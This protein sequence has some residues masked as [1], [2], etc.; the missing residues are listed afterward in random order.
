ML[1]QGVFIKRIHDDARL[2]RSPALAGTLSRSRDRYEK[3]FRLIGKYRGTIFVPTTEID[4]LWHTQQCYPKLYY[5]F[6]NLVTGIAGDAGVDWQKR[7]AWRYVDHNDRLDKG[8]L[9][10][11]FEDTER[12]WKVEYVSAELVEPAPKGWKRV[13][14]DREK[15]PPVSLPAEEDENEGAAG[16]EGNKEKGVEAEQKGQGG[17]SEINTPAKQ[18]QNLI[19]NSEN[20][21][22]DRKYNICVNWV[23]ELRKNMEEEKTMREGKRAVEERFTRKEEW[24]MRATVHYYR[25]VEQARVEG[26]MLPVWRDGK[27]WMRSS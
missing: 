7:G 11:G 19:D 22:G 3:F 17:V 8:I 1:R 16:E 12:L 15:S 6:S 20:C 4:L 2:I 25:M 24:G 5:T 18:R 13:F 14:G 21:D 10:N 9:G 27:Q 23:C 26:K